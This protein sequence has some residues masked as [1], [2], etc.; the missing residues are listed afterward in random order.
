MGGKEECEGDGKKDVTRGKKEREKGVFS[1][2]SSR[3]LRDVH[4]PQYL[5]KK[6]PHTDRFNSILSI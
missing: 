2:C 3:E 6:T 5:I 4:F 1:Q